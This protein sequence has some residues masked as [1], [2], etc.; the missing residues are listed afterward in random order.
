MINY[1]QQILDNGIKII[2][3]QDFDSS[4]V[5]LCYTF[6][7][8]SK[9][10]TPDKSGMAHLLEHVL[11]TGTDLFPNYD[12]YLQV[13]G[14][15][16]N[17]YT[18]QD[19]ACFYTLIPIQNL[20]PYLEMEADRFTKLRFDQAS[21]NV[22]KK[23][24]VEEYKETCLNEPYGDLWHHLGGL[25][26][27]N[28]PYEWPPI[29]ADINSINKIRPS[30]LK[31]F[32]NNLYV[33]NRITIAI[34]GP[35]NPEEL[36]PKIEQLFSPIRP[37][38]KNPILQFQRDP[39]KTRTKEIEANVPVDQLFLCYSGTDRLDPNY[40]ID[41]LIIELVFAE[42]SMFLERL[43][44]DKRLINELEIYQ[45]GHFH[46]GLVVVEARPA[47]HVSMQKLVKEF[48]QDLKE[49]IQHE[50]D[51]PSIVAALNRIESQ[52]TFSSLN[53]LNK[54]MNLSYY[55]WL[56]KLE[57]MINELSLY[58]AVT[59]DQIVNRANTLFDL[60]NSFELLYRASKKP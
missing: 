40:I 41:D 49:F 54:A 45:S 21:I 46:N 31:E 60:K 15:D 17:A 47:E 53:V 57:W 25:I 39:P 33:G 43:I 12:D 6:D 7:A 23:V 1:T 42:S 34:S 8:G 38:H 22:Q 52:L 37:N 3:N 13:A 50:L 59:K 56:N 16:G 24:V 44:K 5:A 27:A 35:V 48:D 58:R 18:N 30:D 10:D 32:F 26:Y 2:I 55:G 9:Y 51:E 11:Y 19:I 4:H 28:T 36:I 29:G 14:G 20:L